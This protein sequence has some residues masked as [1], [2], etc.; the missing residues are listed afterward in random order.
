[1]GVCVCGKVLAFPQSMVCVWGGGLPPPQGIMGGCSLSPESRWSCQ[2]LQSSQAHGDRGRQRCR[3]ILRGLLG[4]L[5]ALSEPLRQA[6]FPITL[7]M[8]RTELPFCRLP[9][10][11]SSSSAQGGTL[12]FL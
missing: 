11:N 9:A 2:M 8:D 6:A 4:F 7:R 1:M 12:L 10:S 3:G 5:V